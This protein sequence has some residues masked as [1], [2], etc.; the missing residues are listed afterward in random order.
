[1]PAEKTSLKGATGTSL[2]RTAHQP[3]ASVDSTHL[4]ERNHYVSCSPQINPGANPIRNQI[5]TWWFSVST[6]S[7]F[8]LSARERDYI[9]PTALN[10]DTKPSEV[11]SIIG[12]MQA[13]TKQTIPAYRKT[14][15]RHDKRENSSLIRKPQTVASLTYRALQNIIAVAGHHTPLLLF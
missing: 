11:D 9:R 7:C 5:L 12:A 1:M 6:V 8:P 10:R 4:N 13:R 14:K 15:E 2:G 3:Q